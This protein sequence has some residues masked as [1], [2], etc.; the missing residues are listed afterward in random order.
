MESVQHMDQGLFQVLCYPPLRVTFLP[1]P[2]LFLATSVL[3]L[4]FV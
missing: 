4:A 1:S 3:N 2:S